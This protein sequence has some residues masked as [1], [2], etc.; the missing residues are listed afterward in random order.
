MFSALYWPFRSVKILEIEIIIL[1]ELNSLFNHPDRNDNF[2]LQMK[3]KE[4]KNFSIPFWNRV[5]NRKYK[6][7]STIQNDR[8]YKIVFYYQNFKNTKKWDTA[9]SSSRV[10]WFSKWW[11][12]NIAYFIE[13]DWNNFKIFA[14]KIQATVRFVGISTGSFACF[15]VI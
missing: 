10:W 6:H 3:W 2:P 4:F 1:K 12:C 14:S 15:R 7:S 9:W 11:S 8:R 13:S 5:T